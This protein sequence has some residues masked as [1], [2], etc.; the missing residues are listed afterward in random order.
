MNLNTIN[1][2][3]KDVQDCQQQNFSIIDDNKKTEVYFKDI[4]KHIINKIRKY[5]KVVGCVAWLTNF[6]IL[7]E[8]EK[9]DSVLIIVQEEDFLRPDTNFDGRLEDW[10]EKIHKYYNSLYNSQNGI[11][12]GVCS[13]SCASGLG[14][15]GI[16][17]LG[18]IN[19]DKNPAFPR[20][21]NKFIICFNNEFELMHDPKN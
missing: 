13:I 6:N 9:K 20:M 16:R 11:Y 19:T 1:V 18:K 2:R 5:K 21:H 17:R 3:N 12:L 4:E 15:S 8:L 7:K 14:F 10:K